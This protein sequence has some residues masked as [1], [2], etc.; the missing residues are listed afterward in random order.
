MAETVNAEMMFEIEEFESVREKLVEEQ[1]PLKMEIG[2][3][4]YKV[5]RHK[6]KSEKV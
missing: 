3:K 2:N 1:D 4:L 6:F 5:I